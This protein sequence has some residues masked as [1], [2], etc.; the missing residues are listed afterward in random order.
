MRGLDVSSIFKESRLTM[1]LA[2]PLIVGQVVSMLMG[3]VDTLMIG[4][5]GTDE[6]ATAAFVNVLFTMAY[7]LGIGLFA[8]LSIL[9]AHQHGTSSRESMGEVFRN[10][11]LCSFVVAFVMMVLLL[12]CLP[13]LHWFRQPEVVVTLAPSYLVWLAVSFIPTIPGLMIKSYADAQNH[14]WPVLWVMLGSVLA[15]VV[16]NYILIFGHF[17]CPPL[18]LMGAGIATLLARLLMFAAIFCYL[19]GSARLRPSVPRQWL[20]P[21]DWKICRE[22]MQMG[23]PISGQVFLEFGAFAIGALLIGQF[24]AVALAAHQVTITCAATTFMIPLGL[25][26][27]VSIRVG[28]TVGASELR[29]TY[30]LV[31]GAHVIALLIMAVTAFTFI[32]A[33]E[34]LAGCFTPDLDVVKLAAELFMVVAFFQVFDGAQVVSMSALRGLKDVNLPTLIIFLSFWVG[35]IPF[36][37]WLAFG[38]GL[39]ATGIWIGLAAGLAFAAIILT[40]RLVLKLK[41]CEPRSVTKAQD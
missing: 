32:T 34:W 24:G 21:L 16:F 12:A 38:R 10:G 18:G 15:N 23:L 14:P 30:C 33:G 8:S 17:G 41:R 5:V 27:A 2:L 1:S 20:K 39:E 7:V 22:L 11:F 29:R 9:V 19:K 25:A 6:L 35:G 4:R 36:G 40:L 28:H 3:L 37:A 13:F 31:L 26:M